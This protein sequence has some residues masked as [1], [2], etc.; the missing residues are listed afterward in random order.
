M[1]SCDPTKYNG[2]QT[3][4]PGKHFTVQVGRYPGWQGEGV[5]IFDWDAIK[6]DPDFKWPASKSLTKLGFDSYGMPSK[7][8]YEEAPPAIYP[9][10]CPITYHDTPPFYLVQNPCTPPTHHSVTAPV[11]GPDGQMHNASCT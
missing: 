11:K 3:V 4:Y 5:A 7:F 8:C 1:G 9:K 6:P 10:S 2:L